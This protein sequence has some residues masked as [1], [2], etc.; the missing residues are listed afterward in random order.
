MT[1]GKQFLHTKKRHCLEGPYLKG[2]Y[3]AHCAYA[4]AGAPQAL[5]HS[6]PSPAPQPGAPGFQTKGR[7]EVMSIAMEPGFPPRGTS[8]CARD[9]AHLRFTPSGEEQASP[10]RQTMAIRAVWYTSSSI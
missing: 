5:P 3:T 10:G 1:A 4:E 9:N 7:T 6:T 8:L 2:L